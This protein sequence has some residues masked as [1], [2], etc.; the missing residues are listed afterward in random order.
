[1]YEMRCGGMWDGIGGL[2]LGMRMGMEGL[3][4]VFEVGGCTMEICG[5]DIFARVQRG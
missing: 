2:G 1:M 5:L 3:G 4:L